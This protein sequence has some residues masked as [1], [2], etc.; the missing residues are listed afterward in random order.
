MQH[1][2]D[3]HH[4]ISITDSQLL[5]LQATELRSIGHVRGTG[6]PITSQLTLP[7]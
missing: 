4:I 6:H 7:W 1:F 2:C 3:E 5:K